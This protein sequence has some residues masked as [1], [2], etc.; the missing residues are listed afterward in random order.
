MSKQLI[1]VIALLGVIIVQVGAL[2]A[3]YV[4]RSSA[5]VVAQATALDLRDKADVE[6]HTADRART[7]PAQVAFSKVKHECSASNA[8]ASCS[9]TNFGAG[10]IVTCMQ[11]L[12]VQK[13][14]AGVRLYSM[15][16]C[17]GP[18]RPS[19]TRSVAAPW[20]GG[21]ASDMCKGRNGYLD[22]DQ[23]NFTVIDYDHKP[24]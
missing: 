16:F 18:I 9:V 15:P 14:A 8:E 20:S 4:M 19:E 23:C 1:A 7:E 3:I 13:E 2:F 22:F 12:L 5:A 24:E 10:P 17:S 6:R 11:G 21:R